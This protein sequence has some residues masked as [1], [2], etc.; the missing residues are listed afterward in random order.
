M[1]VALA[2]SAL[3]GVLLAAAPLGSAQTI[4]IQPPQANTGI[5]VVGQGIV[6]AQPNVARIT[7]G[8]EVFDQSLANAQAEAARRMDAVVNKLKAAGI[9]DTH[10]RTTPS[11]INPQ[12][13]HRHHN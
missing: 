4:P 10:I 2:L 8:A 9:P 11:T 6:L 5:S 3:I 13:T 1:L 12:S 7:L